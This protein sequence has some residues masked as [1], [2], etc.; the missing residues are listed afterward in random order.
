MQ[1][2]LKGGISSNLNGVGKA[3]MLTLRVCYM[4]DRTVP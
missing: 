1:T 2:S 3:D 4:N